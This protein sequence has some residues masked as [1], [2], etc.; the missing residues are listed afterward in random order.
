MAGPHVGT[1]A[2]ATHATVT[3]LDSARIMSISETGIETNILDVSHLGSSTWREKLVGDL[4]EPGTVTMEI[5]AD[6]ATRWTPGSAS[7]GALT[8]I[9]KMIAPETGAGQIAGDA[10]LQSAEKT[11]E[12]E[13]VVTWTLIWQWKTGPTFTAPVTP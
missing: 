5:Q 8:I 7:A 10:W 3:A 12:T 1:G 2:S 4:A 11:T 9:D 13:E 6:T